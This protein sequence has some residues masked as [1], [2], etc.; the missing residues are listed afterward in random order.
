MLADEAD[1]LA[2]EANTLADEANTLA[3]EANT[4]ADEA[5]TLA[6]EALTLAWNYMLLLHRDERSLAEFGLSL[7]D[8]KSIGRTCSG[9]QDAVMNDP[10]WRIDVFGRTD[11][12]VQQWPLFSPAELYDLG[13][14][15]VIWAWIE[16]KWYRGTLSL[17]ADPPTPCQL[18]LVPYRVLYEDDLKIVAFDDGQLERWRTVVGT[19]LQR[20]RLRVE[21]WNCARR[22][23][24]T[25][26]ER[27]RIEEACVALRQEIDAVRVPDPRSEKVLRLQED[28]AL[29][30]SRLGRTDESRPMWRHLLRERLHFAPT[31]ATKGRNAQERR[32]RARVT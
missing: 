14:G 21:K 1:T 22:I 9:A 27:S 17:I 12:D 26:G 31:R 29:L 32:V 10:C 5:N 4:L 16:K 3:D 25:A 19:C 28:L 30:L 23:A 7:Q 15:T 18:S 24:L 8:I 11:D 20:R 6:D 13:P 2:D